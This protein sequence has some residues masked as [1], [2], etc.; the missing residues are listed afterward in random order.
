LALHFNPGYA[1]AYNNLGLS[2]GAQGLFDDAIEQ[3]SNSLK[4]KSDFGEA[5]YNIA[6]AY[7]TRG[8]LNKSME[9]FRIARTID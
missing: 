8:L 5:H 1:K 7:R 6:V 3:F 4:L 9:H 2:Y